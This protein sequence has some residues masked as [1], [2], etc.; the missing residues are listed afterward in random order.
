M[1]KI[2][3][4]IN[5]VGSTDRREPPESAYYPAIEFNF[6]LVS[7]LATYIRRYFRTVLKHDP[8]QFRELRIA[9]EK[10]GLAS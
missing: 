3:A 7:E 10:R 1:G 6:I 8:A 9:G 5:L 2:R 4:V